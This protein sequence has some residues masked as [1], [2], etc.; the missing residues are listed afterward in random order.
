MSR[1]V[2]VA[3]ALAWATLFATGLAEAC[4]CSDDAG[5]GS[6]L[7]REDERY[8]ASL[9]ATSRHAL[10]H[11]DAFGHY[12]ALGAGEGEASEELLLRAGLRL[13]QRVEW[14]GELGYAAYRFHAPGTALERVGIGDALLHARAKLRDEGMPHE[15]PWLP[16][17]GVSAL[18]RAPLGAIAGRHDTSFGSGG[19]QLGLGAWELGGGIEARRSLFPKLELLLGA[20]A[21]FR[22]EDH[23]LG[24]TRARQL[25]PRADLSLGARA[26]P[27]A[28]FAATVALRARFSGDVTLDERRLPGTGERLWSVVLGGAFYDRSSK[29]RSS[30]TLSLDPPVSSLSV[31]ST[32]A[33]ALSVALGYGVE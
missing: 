17:L 18:V 31:G 23:V 22:F 8:A 13:P 10:G 29:L 25:G 2:A 4:P 11:F 33:A 32:A 3:V 27:S 12:S 21:A 30:L 24:P 15:S 28:W 19:A 14:L 5:G 16:A 9:V 7:L 26:L 1:N 6:G 20:E